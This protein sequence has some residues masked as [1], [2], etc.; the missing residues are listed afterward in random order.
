MTRQQSTQDTFLSLLPGITKAISIIGVL[1]TIIF[2]V[3]PAAIGTSSQ[4]DGYIPNPGLVRDYNPVSGNKDSN[5]TVVEFF[6]FQCPGCKGVHPVVQQI[7]DEY[8]NDVRF[9]YKNFPLTA[10]HANAESAAI[11]AMAAA[12]QGKYFEFADKLYAYQDNPGL[13]SRTQEQIANEVGLDINQWN[14]DRK[15]DEIIKQVQWDLQDGKTAVLPVEEGSSQ[16]TTVDATPTFVFMKDGKILYRANGMSADEFRS[17]LDKILGRP[18]K[19]ETT[20]TPTTETEG[21]TAN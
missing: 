10:I 18:A 19:S 20:P 17:R 9:V 11:S 3:L 13:S 16:T 2:A 4:L 15:S 12:K 21:N 7:S 5:I 6:D 14:T 1:A 8:K